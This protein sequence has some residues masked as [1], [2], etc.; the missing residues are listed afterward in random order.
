MFLT[1]TVSYRDAA[2]PKDDCQ[3]PDEDESK[4]DN[5]H[6]AMASENAVRERP[7]TN[8]A[9]DFGGPQ[10]REVPED[11]AGMP[12]RTAAKA[13]SPAVA[14]MDAD[15]EHLRYTISGGDDMG[16]FSINMDTGQLS[17]KASTKLDFEGDQTTYVVEVS[18]TD[19]FDGSDSTTVTITVTNVNEAPDLML[20]GGPDVEPAD[21]MR[22]RA[23]R[24]PPGGR[25]QGAARRSED[26][27]VGDGM[28]LNWDEDTDIADWTT[29]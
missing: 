1:A 16:A 18:V 23:G 2:S 22:R 27:L 6:R 12:A 13:I 4:A 17:A 15:D 8:S 29:A 7:L 26:A 25:L 21:T 3:T 28:G 14:A 5:Q 10:T 20:S 9:P 11:D 24:H 19:P